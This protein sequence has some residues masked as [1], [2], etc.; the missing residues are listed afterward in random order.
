M[1]SDEN[2]SSGFREDE[3][4]KDYAILYMYTASVEGQITLGDKIVIVTKR[5]FSTSIIHCKFQQ[6]I[7]LRK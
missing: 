1:K 6:L 4:F 7:H 3:T 5:V 2:W